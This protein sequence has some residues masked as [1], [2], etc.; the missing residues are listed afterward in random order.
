MYYNINSTN[1]QFAR[2][3]V[4]GRLAQ[5]AQTWHSAGFALKLALKQFLAVKKP[6]K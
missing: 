1:R 4:P 3:A 2:C 6:Q 5:S